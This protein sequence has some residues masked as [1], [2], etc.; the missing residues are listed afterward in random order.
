MGNLET[1]KK[2]SL[3]MDLSFDFFPF[4]GQE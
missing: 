4:T 2:G 1:P 3:M